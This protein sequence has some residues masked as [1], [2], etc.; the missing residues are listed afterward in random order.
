M[1]GTNWRLREHY[2]VRKYGAGSHTLF[3][4]AGPVAGALGF[5][6]DWNNSIVPLHSFVSLSFDPSQDPDS[7]KWDYPDW[8]LD[9]WM[10]GRPQ[11]YEAR[12]FGSIWPLEIGLHGTDVEEIE[13]L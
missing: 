8:V 6:L 9:P 7:G 4:P 10:D 1:N 2:D 5:P 13:S 12:A 3:N 11:I